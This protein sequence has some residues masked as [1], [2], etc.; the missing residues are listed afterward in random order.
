MQT[1]L[2]TSLISIFNIANWNTFLG[3]G[4]NSY[5]YFLVSS[6]CCQMLIFI[7]QGLFYY[8]GYDFHI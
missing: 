8:C 6:N 2:V 3:R 5:E 1:I 4:L 7:V